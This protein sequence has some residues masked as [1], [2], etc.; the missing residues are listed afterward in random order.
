LDDAILPL[1]EL[2]SVSEYKENYR[3][4]KVRAESL[5]DT[6]AQPSSAV[7]YFSVD[8]K[9]TVNKKTYRLP[10]T[11]LKKF[12]AELK[13]WLC[14][15]TQLGLLEKDHGISRQRGTKIDHGWTIHRN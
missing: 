10:N 2:A 11:E 7:T 1:V 4:A 6:S 15:D 12:S 3:T 8:N 5:F 9:P 14:I 13:D